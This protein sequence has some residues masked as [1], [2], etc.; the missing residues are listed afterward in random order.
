MAIPHPGRAQAEKL[1]L[2]SHWETRANA[3][4]RQSRHYSY[5]LPTSRYNDTSSL[6]R[7]YHR[8]QRVPSLPQQG[9]GHHQ[10]LG[11]PKH[12]A[13]IESK[14]AKEMWEA[15][16]AKF[17][18]ISPMSISRLVLDT[19]RIRLSD[20][21]DIYKY[22]SKYQ[23]AYDSVCSLIPADFELPAKGAELLLQVG[24]LTGMG[25][26]YLSIVSIM[27]KE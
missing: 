24:L 1:C 11:C 8:N 20:C 9:R 12:Q 17:Q 3:G 14:D 7:P 13:A 16:K 19:T 6:D 23:E 27:E 10:E 25:N 15:L 2:G 26:E 21:T 18:H 5:G 22:C 4:K